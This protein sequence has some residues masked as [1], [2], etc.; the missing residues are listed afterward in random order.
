[1][2]V[3]KTSASATSGLS[4]PQGANTTYTLVASNATAGGGA[5]A[6]QVRDLLPSGFSFVSATATYANGASGPATLT[7]QGTAQEPV[8][9]DFALPAGGTVTIELTVSVNA[10][11]APGMYR[12]RAEISYPVPH[13]QVLLPIDAS[14]PPPTPMRAATPPIRPVGP[15]LE[16]ITAMPSAALLVRTSLCWPFPGPAT[17]PSP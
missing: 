9:G 14:R 7:N 8:L 15:F 12:D 16:A 1:M 5:A 4:V 11:Q 17:M 13:A 3:T 2:S 6:V 10:A